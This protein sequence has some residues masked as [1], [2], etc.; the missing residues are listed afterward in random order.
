[1]VK[2]IDPAQPVLV[3]GA[4][5]FLASWICKLLVEAGYTVRGTVRRRDD[6]KK[7]GHLQT[8][9]QAGPGRL[10]LFEADLLRHG[11]FN[12]AMKGCGLVIHTA[13]PFVV[14]NVKDAQR[15][16]IDPAVEGTRNVLLSASE[17]STVQRIVLTSSVAAI[18]GDAIEVLDKPNHEFTEADWNLVADQ[19]YQPYSYSKTLAEKTAWAM[20][21]EQQQWDLVT[22]NPA[23]VLGPS[24]SRRS[25]GTSVGFMRDMIRGQ[26]RL[27]APALHFGLVDV[28]EAALAHILAGFTPE[29]QGR[30]ILAH[31]RSYEILAMAQIIAR[32]YGDLPLP[33]GHLP[34][35]LFGLIGPFLGFSRRYQRNNLGQSFAFNHQRSLD[36]GIQYRSIEETLWDQVADLRGVAP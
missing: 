20:Q 13:S 8:L 7:Y 32:K 6:L 23:F 35:W 2:N 24:L 19:H 14:A 30:Y 26:F 28:R 25:D 11:S 27:G 1:M 9:S 33:K 34:R 18:Y 22:I 31:T 5:G 3:T 12:K 21:A 10:D 36:L 16:L 15:E 17:L 29:A 4:G